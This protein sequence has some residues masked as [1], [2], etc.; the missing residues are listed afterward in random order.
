MDKEKIASHNSATGERSKTIFHTLMIP[1]ARCQS[2][3][4]KEQL[5]SGIRLFDIR[6][7]LDTFTDSI[8]CAHG[9]WKTDKSA[10]DILE[11]IEDYA[12]QNR[13][14]FYVSIVYEGTENEM[15]KNEFIE[16]TDLFV[17]SFK[18]IKF[19]YTAYKHSLDNYSRYAYVKQY[20]QHPYCVTDFD[21]LGGDNPHRFFPIPW[22][23][24]KLWKNKTDIPDNA[25]V[26]RD[27]V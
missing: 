15:P 18:H 19:T 6:I 2:K 17:D 3:T 12:E 9:L 27:F 1:F 22:L 21:N 25:Y 5:E 4:I 13:D 24:H 26:Y 23:W 14:R 16:M 20:N 11:E 8:K 10:F 7:I